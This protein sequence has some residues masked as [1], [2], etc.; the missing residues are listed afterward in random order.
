MKLLVSGGPFLIYVHTDEGVR[1]TLHF[2]A[3]TS[4]ESVGPG[5]P[6]GKGGGGGMKEKGG[7][8]LFIYGLLFDGMQ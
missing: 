6:Q 4:G 8:Y 5:D 7:I 2:C 1:Y 3:V